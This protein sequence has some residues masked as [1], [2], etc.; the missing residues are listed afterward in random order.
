M[1]RDEA[2]PSFLTRV[3]A[4]LVLAVAAWFL[5]KVV[6]NLVVGVA[7]IVAVVIA[8]VGVVWAVRTLR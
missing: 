3:L 1:Q 8:I 7:W 4:I 5:L 2:G 6:I